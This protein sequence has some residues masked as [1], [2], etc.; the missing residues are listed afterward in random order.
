MSNLMTASHEWATRP[1]D[2]RFTTLADLRAKVDSRRR[3][4]RAVDVETDGVRAVHENG[5]ILINSRIAP[6][7][8]THWSFGQLCGAVGVPAGYMRTLKGNPGL[9]VDNLNWGFGN[10]GRDTNKFMTLAGDDVNTLQAV[11]SPTY[12]R[13]WDADVVDAVQR[14]VDRSGGRFHNPLAY[15]IGA[16][17]RMTQGAG[18]EWLKAPAGLYASDRDVFCFMIDGGSRLEV[19]DNPRDVLNRGFFVSNSEVGAAKFK[20]TTFLFREACGN[21]IVWG[22]EN[23]HTVE[24]RHTSGA[25]ARFDR[26]AFPALMRYVESSATDE[27]DTIRAAKALRLPT[28]DAD[29]VK[30]ASRFEITRTELKEAKAHAEREEGAFNSHWDLV[31]GLTAYARG[32][33]WMDTRLDLERRAGKVLAAVGK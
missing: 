10:H 30:L 9:M 1:S 4:S 5:R 31:Q 13:I 14:V 6:A 28:D 16:D 29:L 32:F 8:P 20:L 7:T 22:A 25:P 23:V 15:V 24:I 21:H 19:D 26:E 12:G 11:T 27:L 17:G 2:Q 18:G 33:E 3:I